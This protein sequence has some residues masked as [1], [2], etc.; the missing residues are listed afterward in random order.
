VVW[1]WGGGGG[2]A[3]PWEC[4]RGKGAWE[5]AGRYARGWLARRRGRHARMAGRRAGRLA[6]RAL[7]AQ[8]QAQGTRTS[9]PCGERIGRLKARA[10]ERK[11]GGG[12]GV[13][14][15]L[16]ELEDHLVA[17]RDGAGERR[18]RDLREDIC[19]WHITLWLCTHV[20]VDT[21]KRDLALRT[22]RG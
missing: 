3:P 16:Q 19:G 1:W 2:R 10:R 4:R 15:A 12:V 18:R 20:K 6:S 8:A 14:A 11:V 17:T 7:K 5:E 9:S 22:A 21:G 13:L